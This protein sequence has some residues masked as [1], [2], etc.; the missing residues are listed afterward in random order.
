MSRK[1]LKSVLKYGRERLREFGIDGYALDAEVLLRHAAGLDRVTLLTNHE[2]KL[3]DQVIEE[4][5]KYLL[6]RQRRMPVAYITKNVEFMSLPMHIDKRALIPRPDTEILVEGA[7][8]LIDGL[9]NRNSG[10]PISV[11]ELCTGSGC[12]A[13][14]LAYYRPGIQV[15]ATDLYD[16]ALQLASGNAKCYSACSN[17]KFLKGDLYTPVSGLKFDIVI[18]NPPY[19]PS[20]DIET[21]CDDVKLYEPAPALDGGADGLDFYRRLCGGAMNMLNPGGFVMFEIGFDQGAA[22]AKLLTEAGFITEVIP[23]LSGHD[24]VVTGAPRT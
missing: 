10:R 22:V 6:L 15:T 5:E 11:L 2:I 19:I 12:V 9:S 7:L 1:N 20:A 17:I 3:N 18:A 14:A 8:A 13:I 16:D 23:D 24:R 4:Y 21:L